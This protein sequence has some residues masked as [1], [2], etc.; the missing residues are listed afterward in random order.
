MIIK[1]AV[2][3]DDRDTR[4]MMVLLIE[5]TLG[6]QHVGHYDNAE[7][8]IRRLPSLEPDVVLMDIHLPGITGIE[9]VRD[10]KP[11]LPR[12]EFIMCTLLEEAET[13]YDALRSGASGYLS[14]STAPLKMIEAIKDAKNGGSPMSSEIARKVVGF[15]HAEERK[16]SELDKLTPREQE[17][18]GHLTK[19][20][21]YKEIAGILFISVETVRKHIRNIYEKLQVGSRT[22]AINKIAQ[23]G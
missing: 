23:S 13:I 8:A 4:E 18:L 7:D 1:V 15:F 22:D 16:S 11:L 19:G 17:I 2:V 3:E 9:C 20:Y 6:L 12:T 10:L 5:Q 14:K 21:R